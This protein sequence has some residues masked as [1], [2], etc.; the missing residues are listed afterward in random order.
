[1]SG[2]S[3]AELITAARAGSVEVYGL[4]R[5]FTAYVAAR[6]A[7]AYPGSPLV[8]VCADETTARRL[9]EDIELFAPPRDLGDPVAPPPALAIPGLDTSPYADIRVDPD[10][11]AARMGALYRLARRGSLVAPIVVVSA[12]SLIRRVIPRDQLEALA[13]TVCKGQSIDRDATAQELT[14]AGYSR[15][16]V[17]EDPGTFAVR[18][19][20]LDVFSPLYRY[21]ARIELFGDEIESIRLFD[22]DTQRTLRDIDELHLPPVRETVITAGADVRT[23]ILAAADAAHH[24]SAA[25]RRVLEQIDSGEDFIGI[26]GLIPA[27]HGQ[28]APLWT[29]LSDALD[30]GDPQPARW[31][32]LDPDA[33]MRAAEDELEVAE[34]RY[35][36]RLSDGRLGFPPGEHYVL[37]EELEDSLDGI[38]PR[39]EARSLE[40]AGDDNG[41]M[42]SGDGE[43]V[44]SLRFSVD[45]N[46]T[47][48][49]ELERARKL[50]ADELLRPLVRSIAE[51][52]KDNWRI[53]V[54]AGSRERSGQLAAL[55]NDYDVPSIAAKSAAKSTE[56]NAPG[57]RELHFDEIEPGAPPTILRG[58]LS[59]GFA[60]PAD[61]IVLLS[62]DD[63]FGPRRRSSARQRA[64]AKRARAALTGGT[65]DFSQLSIG[66]HVVHDLHGVGLYRGLI[67][68]PVSQEGPEIDF[69]HLE[70]RGGQLYLPVYRLNEVARYIGAE[71]HT[72]RLDKLGGITWEKT[73]R[74][75][76]KQI[77]ALAEELLQIYAQR[78]AL[79]GFAYPAGDSMYREFEATFPFEETPDQQ[80]AIDDVM[81]DMESDKPMDRLVCGDVGYGKTEVAIRAILKAALGGKQA[82]FLAPTTVL[83]EQH[84]RT[85]SERF[86]GW[87][88]ELGRLSRFQSKA[89]QVATI[90]GL[91]AGTID[92]VV[93]TH[94]L[95]SND[96]RF[97]GLGLIVIDEEQRFGVAHKEKLKR[98]RTQI[99]VLTL[100]ATPIPRT[101]HLAMAGLKDLSIIAT[102]PADRR[103][104]RT[105][106]ARYD[107][108][109]LR[110]GIRREI[111]RGGQVFFVCPRIS[112]AAQSARKQAA[113]RGNKIR[114]RAATS[115]P[116]RRSMGEWAD[117]LQE[118]V[119]DAKVVIAHGQMK[120]AALEKAMVSF[121][122]GESDLLVS[123]TVIENGLDIPRAN[124]MFVANADRFGLSQLYQ[125]RGRIGRSKERA[126]CYLMVPPL[127]KLPTDARRRLEALQR[128]SDLGAGFQIASHDLEIR[129][130]GELLGAKQSGAIAA[131]GFETYVAMLEE[132]VAE[133]Q[134]RESPAIRRARDPELNVEIPG[135]IPDDYIPDTNQR[136]ELYK[137]LSDAESE[138][139]VKQLLDEMRDRYGN[140]PPEVITLG[141]LMV[142][143]VHARGLRARSLELTRSR[144]VLALA[145]D[146]PLGPDA[147]VELVQDPRYRLTPDM[148][149][150]R[151]FSP[152]R[153]APGRRER[154]AMLAAARRLCYV[155]PSRSLMNIV[156]EE[157]HAR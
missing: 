27:F 92:A 147:L 104:I 154:A 75:A 55:L 41:G 64:A 85:M 134:N 149:L 86:S 46:R 152:R 70:Y 148:R 80:K 51:W 124:T 48:R 118:L 49:A 88:I 122:A 78:A 12:A 100:T 112:E 106:V 125:L 5:P 18:G 120:P 89:E 4:T 25:T 71:G 155:I 146:T 69:L 108:A 67:K 56:S 37:R 129:G 121:V 43:R 135:Y 34:S 60:L 98:F 33:I 29:Y 140:L 68:L 142:L 127:D 47:L 13:V 113:R 84:Y 40:L 157:H 137:R 139:E 38:E 119:P 6:L 28:L 44:G 143:K 95:L 110:E 45:D 94:R 91:A 10:A 99:D 156:K 79:P 23:K 128:F 150:A 130:G 83:V 101:L 20:V 77:K 58:K 62:A 90:K 117:H 102:P 136:L 39:I 105:F 14:K 7:G 103:S 54:A 63:I 21:P 144:L 133:L 42:E 138:D 19:G 114:S 87:P 2:A 76:S 1:M 11:L 9:V 111:G 73:R 132:A 126:F 50:A 116:A 115:M 31:L 93:G 35:E 53:A 82:A 131:V 97:K 109:V 81:A 141:D 32:I 57:R 66:D 26:D 96:V 16:T 65:G 8:I 59:E 52:R 24:P 151:S 72:P 3:I 61:K 153:G 22:P 74:K 145:D 15:A 123:T 36:D 107:D 30:S 17:V